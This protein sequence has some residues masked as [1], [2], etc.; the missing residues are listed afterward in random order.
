MFWVFFFPQTDAKIC[1]IM[2]DL[3]EFSPSDLQQLKSFGS[4]GG[5]GVLLCWADVTVW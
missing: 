3:E 5:V 4:K 2:K 1:C